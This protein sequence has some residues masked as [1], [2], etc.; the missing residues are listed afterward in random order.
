M[1]ARDV[2]A[3]ED[4][5]KAAGPRYLPRLDCQY[6]TEY[7]AHKQRASFFNATARTADERWCGFDLVML[8]IGGGN[9]S[10]GANSIILRRNCG[11]L[12]PWP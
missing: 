5:V 6:D 8:Q 2:Y 4:A 1:R 11:Y 9:R 7:A 12:F 3:G 10:T